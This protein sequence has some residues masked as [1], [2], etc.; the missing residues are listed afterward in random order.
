MLDIIPQ[1]FLV[2]YHFPVPSIDNVP[3]TMYYKDNKSHRP[4]S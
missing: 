3:T 1:T 2:F 4:L